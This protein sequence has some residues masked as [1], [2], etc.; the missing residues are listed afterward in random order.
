[1]R[2]RLWHQLG[3]RP[4]WMNALMVFCAYM[5]FVDVPMDLVMTPTSRDEEVWF[6][7]RF[8]GATAKLLGL[9]HWLV[10]GAGVYGFWRMRAWM[11]PWAALYAGQVA[12]SAAVWPLLYRSDARGLVPGVVFAY[13]ALQL[14]RS[15]ARFQ[16]VGPGPVSSRRGR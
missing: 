12:L 10:Y 7:V 2:D 16:A 3:R 6:G 5:A 9:L 1:M 14:W 15:R 11:W 4:W 13:V 8:V